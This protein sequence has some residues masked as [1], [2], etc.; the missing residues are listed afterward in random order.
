MDSERVAYVYVYAYVYT[1]VNVYMKLRI[2]LSGSIKNFVG[3]LM[4]DGIESVDCFWYDVPFHNANSLNI[5]VFPS[6]DFFIIF[7][8]QGLAIFVIQIFYLIS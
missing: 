2:A 6:S 3:I 7:F 1:H 8:L 5:G 4:G